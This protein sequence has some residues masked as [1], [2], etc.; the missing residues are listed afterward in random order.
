MVNLLEKCS[1]IVVTQRL[2]LTNFVLITS[3]KRIFPKC[4]R[5]VYHLFNK[6]QLLQFKSTVSMKSQ[7][8][9]NLDSQF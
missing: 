4:Q 2:V 1:D 3:F 6:L 5:L 8:K 9:H 7:N